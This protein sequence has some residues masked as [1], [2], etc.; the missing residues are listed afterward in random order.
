LNDFYTRSTAWRVIL[1]PLAINPGQEIIDLNPVDQD[2]RV[3][4]VLGAYRRPS[5]V[6][7][8]QILPASPVPILGGQPGPPCSYWMHRYDQLR[9]WPTPDKSYGKTLFVW[10]SLVP[11]TLV[12]ILPDMSYTH[13]L[14]GLS[15]GVLARLYSIPKRPWTDQGLAASHNKIYRQ[16]IALARD[17]SRR[18]YGPADAWTRFPRFA[19]RAG[20]Q[21]LPRASG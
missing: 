17:E 8:P 10:A 3:Q 19:G 1:G 4:F 20:S 21:I 18:G 12:A 2:A 13:H 5:D 6:Q 7:Y 15:S 14:E 16:E 11:T 9:L